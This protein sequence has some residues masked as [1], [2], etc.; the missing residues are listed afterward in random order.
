MWVCA[1]LGQ[2]FSESTV[3]FPHGDALISSAQQI[4]HSQQQ[5][6][7]E[8]KRHRKN[9]IH[10]GRFTT[11]GTWV[12]CRV[13]DS[14]EKH[15]KTRQNNGVKT[16]KNFFFLWDWKQQSQSHYCFRV[17]TKSKN[18]GRRVGC[19]KLSGKIWVSSVFFSFL[20]F[21][22]S[23][24]AEGFSGRGRWTACR[25]YWDPDASRKSPGGHPGVRASSGGQRPGDQEHQGWSVEQ[26]LPTNPGALSHFN[27]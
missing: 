22:E 18:H 16:W 17:S 21:S 25:L 7:G 23:E 19:G 3:E 4:L 2:S 8:Q 27:V 1:R 13:P 24:E 20:F 5:R 15:T 12:K 14:N 10:V 11:T 9:T 26:G 6:P